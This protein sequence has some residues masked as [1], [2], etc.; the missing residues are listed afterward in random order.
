MAP[1]AISSSM[2][3][4]SSKNGGNKSPISFRHTAIGAQIFIQ[5]KHSS[6]DGAFGH[7]LSQVAI[8]HHYTFLF[9]ALFRCKASTSQPQK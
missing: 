3:I 2:P 4:S 7:E 8:T 6:K 1:A 5:T 9:S